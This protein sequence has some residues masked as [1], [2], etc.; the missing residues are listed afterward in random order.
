M[1]SWS[2]SHW[3]VV[4]IVFAIHAAVIGLIVW[5]VR[6]KKSVTGEREEREDLPKIIPAARHISS[7]RLKP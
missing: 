4:F 7:R 2:V 1:S 5:L 6:L 3:I